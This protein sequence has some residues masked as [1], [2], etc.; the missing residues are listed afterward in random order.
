MPGSLHSVELYF[1]FKKTF[2]TYT[3]CVSPFV[4]FYHREL[5]INNNTIAAAFTIPHAP[6]NTYSLRGWIAIRQ[7]VSTLVA[8]SYTAMGNSIEAGWELRTVSTS[9]R[10]IFE[11]EWMDG[12]RISKRN[13]DA[14]MWWLGNKQRV[15]ISYIGRCERCLLYTFVNV[16]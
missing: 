13:G 7:S 5:H 14:K 16:Q 11:W 10:L 4:R 1:S 15:F 12:K 6:Y 9:Y 2:G 3:V 8:K